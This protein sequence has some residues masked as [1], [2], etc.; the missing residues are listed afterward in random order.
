M[1]KI[2][3]DEDLAQK[4]KDAIE[5]VETYLK[6][7]YLEGYKSANGEDNGRSAFVT[8]KENLQKNIFAKTLSQPRSHDDIKQI[9]QKK[10]ELYQKEGESERAKEEANQ[11]EGGAPKQGKID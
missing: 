10:K 11:K 2:K 3:K 1:Q 5:K 6:G 8:Q 7:T 9:I 4:L